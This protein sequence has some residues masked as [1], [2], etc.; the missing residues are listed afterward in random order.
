VARK[1]KNYFPEPGDRRPRKNQALG[2]YL[3]P[4]NFG[5]EP[6]EKWAR[7]WYKNFLLNLVEHGTIKHAAT[8]SGKHPAYASFVLNKDVRLRA[9]VDEIR[10][11]WVSE[12][13]ASGFQRARDGWLEPVFHE[14]QVCGHKRRYSDALTIFMLKM[15]DRRRYLPE[16]KGSS[17]G[18][19]D[20]VADLQ[21]LISDCTSRMELD[22]LGLNPTTEAT[23][24]ESE[25]ERSAAPRADDSALD[26]APETGTGTPGVLPG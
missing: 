15:W 2:R 7:P 22:T 19:E 5:G 17:G 20:R 4:E 26:E 6:G 1:K 18:S 3:V 10:F 21:T 24:A 14:G 16:L 13:E 11:S 8:A 9:A 23:D 12:I 25:P